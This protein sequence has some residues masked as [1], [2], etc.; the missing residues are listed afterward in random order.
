M[1]KFWKKFANIVFSQRTTIILLLLAQV[2]FLLFTFFQLSEHSSAIY[3]TFTVLGLALAVYILNKPEN[4]AY[5]LAWIIPLLAI[6]VFATIAY[7]I[8]SNQYSTKRVRNAHIKK[9]A[10]TKPFLRQ[11]QDI[12]T[13][14]NI[15]DKN[16]YHLARYVDKYGGYPIYKNTTV[17]YFKIGC[18]L[19]TS[20]S[21][22]DTR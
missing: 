17:E 11:D 5:K 19:Y 3:Y 10:G 16:V 4:P 9:C 12:L 15:E 8:L 2:L 20:P 22:R 18:L 7:F 1:T 6:P 14:L 13:E 21:P